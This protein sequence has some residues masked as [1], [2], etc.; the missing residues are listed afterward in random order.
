[1]NESEIVDYLHNRRLELG[2]SCRDV[3]EVTNLLPSTIWRIETRHSR[4]YLGSILQYAEG[5]GLSLELTRN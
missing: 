4:A 5:L 3:S 2:M 1:M